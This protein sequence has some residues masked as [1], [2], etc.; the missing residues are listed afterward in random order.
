MLRA[1][2]RMEAEHR[3]ML[4]RAS[5]L[6]VRSTIRSA[7]MQ[8]LAAMI[9]AQER[10]S[11]MLTVELERSAPYVVEAVRRVRETDR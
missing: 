7:R 6:H 11:D 4:R 9:D 3:G 1:L 8:V 10:R 5:K 2:Q